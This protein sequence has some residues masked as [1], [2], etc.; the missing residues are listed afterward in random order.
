M[1]LREYQRHVFNK[2]LKYNKCLLFWSRQKGKSYII[3]HI[4]E[5]FVKNNHDEDILFFVNSVHNISYSINKIIKNIGYLI[6][7]KNRK[8]NSFYFIN[9]N[10]IKFLPINKDYNY[11][12]NILKPSLIIFDEFIVFDDISIFDILINYIIRNNCKTIFTST[13]FDINVIR[14]LDVKNDFYINVYSDDIEY[15]H[16][17]IESISSRGYPDCSLDD[18]VKKLSY[19]P[20]DLLDYMTPNFW[21]REKLKNLKEVNGV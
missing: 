20:K 5:N 11:D 10:H 6:S 3:S 9:N 8:K 7:L 4:I 17:V 15:H 13:C 1:N 21:R 2:Y 19:K 14:R 16:Q 18:L 12:L